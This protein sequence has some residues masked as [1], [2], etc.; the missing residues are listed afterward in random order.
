MQDP[1]FSQGTSELIHRTVVASGAK[2]SRVLVYIFFL[3]CHVASL[4][5]MTNCSEVPER[6]ALP[7]LAK[8]YVSLILPIFNHKQKISIVNTMAASTNRVFSKSPDALYQLLAGEAV[9]LN[10]KS[11]QY[12]GLD[13]IG[14]RVWEVLVDDGKVETIVATLLAEY[15]VDEMELRR[16]VD[17]LLTDLAQAK[18]II[19]M[20]FP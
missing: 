17:L 5:A 18:L 14:T 10:V 16:D 6:F 2:Q 20:D 12:F 19:P 13:E 8:P 9:L 1:Q 7:S 4:L 15:D 3:D 11:E